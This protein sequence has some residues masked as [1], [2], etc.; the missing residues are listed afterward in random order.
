M[1]KLKFV[2]QNSRAAGS[3]SS[4]LRPDRFGLAGFYGIRRN[5]GLLICPR[6]VLYENGRLLGLASLSREAEERMG[7]LNRSPRKLRVRN[8]RPM[9][10]CNTGL[11]GRRSQKLYS[12]APNF[13]NNLNT[14]LS[15]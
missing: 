3:K 13:G 15:S 5:I 6:K 1:K 2:L 7:L 12:S 14:A 10:F 11:L 8:F 9:G 4:L